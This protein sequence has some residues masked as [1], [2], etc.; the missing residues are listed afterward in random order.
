MSRS[1]AERNR[2]VAAWL[3]APPMRPVV[4]AQAPSCSDERVDAI[5]HTVC[6]GNVADVRVLGCVNQGVGRVA[7]RGDDDDEA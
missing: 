7:R 3:W 4:E 1:C 5:D 2:A 6:A